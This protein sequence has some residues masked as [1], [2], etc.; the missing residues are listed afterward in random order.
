MKI[1]FE[2]RLAA[3]ENKTFAWEAHLDTI[4]S[5]Y[6]ESCDYPDDEWVILHFDNFITAVWHRETGEIRGY[7]FDRRTDA[8][9]ERE[10][11]LLEYL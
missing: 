6:L 7:Y 1:E 4:D 3:I 10:G 8:E 11:G 5:G 2:K 9:I